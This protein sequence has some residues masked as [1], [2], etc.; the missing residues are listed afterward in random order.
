MK[1]I[2]WPITIFQ[3]LSSNPIEGFLAFSW[4]NSDYD[5]KMLKRKKLQV[6]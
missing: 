6:L 3:Q 5:K 4:K 2:P 1:A